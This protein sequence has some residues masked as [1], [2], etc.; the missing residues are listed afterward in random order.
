MMRVSDVLLRALKVFEGCKLVAYADAVGVWTIGYGHTKGVK[1]GMVITQGQAE[2][3][4]KGDLAVYER[5]VNRLGVAKTQGQFDA[6]V[7]FAFNLGCSALENSSLVRKLRL[8]ADEAEIRSEFAKW[9]F[10]GGK[11]LAGLVKRRAWEAD[12]FFS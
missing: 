10:A 4:L 11:V 7:D 1:K 6:L 5:C 8:G 12:R 2:Q 9:R 3:L